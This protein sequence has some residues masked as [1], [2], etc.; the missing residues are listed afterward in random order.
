MIKV[1]IFILPIIICTIGLFLWG[2]FCNRRF[3]LKTGIT[4]AVL[5]L[6]LG[7]F[8]GGLCLTIS[9][10]YLIELR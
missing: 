9:R 2:S 1:V 4:T 7:I 6:F 10:E 3:N 8:L 5:G